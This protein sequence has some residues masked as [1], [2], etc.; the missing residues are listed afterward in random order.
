MIAAILKRELRAFF[1]PSFFVVV[2][3]ASVYFGLYF[4]SILLQYANLSSQVSQGSASLNYID[5]LMVPYFSS[6]NFVLLIICPLLSIRLF[7]EEY[8]Q[9]TFELLL[10]SPLSSWQI[11]LGKY[12]AACLTITA[13]LL[14]AMSYLLSSLFLIDL[15]WLHI[16]CSVV[17]L[18][19]LSYIYL[20]IG[21]FASSLTSSVILAGFISIVLCLTLWLLTIFR[22]NQD[23]SYVMLI[24]ELWLGTHLMAFLRGGPDIKALVIYSSHIFFFLFLCQQ[25]VESHRWR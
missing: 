6:I 20:A 16:L 12:L 21:L 19:L 23:G 5:N 17:G 11:V 4:Y 7:S 8:K 10:S 14:L 1:R 25:V 13:I 15:S 2:A 3:L 18:I 22:V 24:Q 9:N